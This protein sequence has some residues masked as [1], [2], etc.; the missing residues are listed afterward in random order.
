MPRCLAQPSADD[1]ST[2]TGRDILSL[3]ADRFGFEV[4][5]AFGNVINAFID[6]TIGRNFDPENERDRR[7]I[8]RVARVDDGKIDSGLIPPTHML[9]ALA[10][11]PKDTLV[12]KHWTPD[13]CLGRASQEPK[14]PRDPKFDVLVD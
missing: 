14:A 7:F 3:L 9:A 11:E 5:A 4:F 10:V 1:G 13:F 2:V 6:E 8:D 12:Y